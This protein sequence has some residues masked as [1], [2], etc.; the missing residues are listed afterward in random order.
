M[1]V[2]IH[3]YRSDMAEVEWIREVS[4]SINFF[5]NRGSEIDRK[6]IFEV[7]IKIFSI[8]VLNVLNPSVSENTM[9]RL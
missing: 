9:L 3:S 6:K 2:L 7:I 5:P 4:G 8:R 1:T